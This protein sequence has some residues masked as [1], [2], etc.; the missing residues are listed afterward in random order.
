MNYRAAA[1]QTGRSLCPGWNPG[2]RNWNRQVLLR[3][4]QKRRTFGEH[5][6]GTVVF[7]YLPSMWICCSWICHSRIRPWSM[8]LLWFWLEWWLH[9]WACFPGSHS[10]PGTSAGAAGPQMLYRLLKRTEATKTHFVGLTASAGQPSV[11]DA[12]IPSQLWL[13]RQQKGLTTS[14]KRL[15]KHKLIAENWAQIFMDQTVNF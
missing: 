12:L 13:T 7:V 5:L 1:V 9:L 2:T 10:S 8:S 6:V 15:L 14:L 3:P 11:C 4:G